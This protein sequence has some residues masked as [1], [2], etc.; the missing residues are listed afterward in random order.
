MDEDRDWVTSALERYEQPLLRFAASIVGRESAADVVQDTFVS[1]CKA[2]RGQVESHLAAWLFTVCKHRAF[3][4]R[5]ARGRLAELVEEDGMQ[6]PDSGPMTRTERRESMSR[7]LEV[8]ERLGA[9]ER[10]IVIL[11][12]SG[13]LKYKEIAEVMQISVSN[14][15]V[16][17]HE[18]IKT[19]RDEL[20]A[21]SA[22]EPRVAR[23]LP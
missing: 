5:R 20:G 12:F 21:E 19:I 18:A 8:L 13:G 14:V 4:V 9:R 17:L 7:V 6:S 23:S 2:D 11:K 10:Q 3:D 16:I 1:L 15:G 22:C